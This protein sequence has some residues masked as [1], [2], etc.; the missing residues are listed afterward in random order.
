MLRFTSIPT[1]TATALLLMAIACGPVV[2]SSA[3]ESTPE[4][5]DPPV[6]ATYELDSSGSYFGFV[7]DQTLKAR[8]F[9]PELNQL[10]PAIDP[11]LAASIAAEFIE[12]TRIAIGRDVLIDFCGDGEGIT[13]AF[14][15]ATAFVDQPISW[16][17]SPNTSE[18]WNQP[19]VIIEF[20][21]P[22]LDIPGFHL[23]LVVQGPFDGVM[24][25][26][27][28]SGVGNNTVVFDNPTCGD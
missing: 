7:G 16:S 17:V 12:N 26:W 1:F 25:S 20:E 10:S 6:T 11:D 23:E 22:E 28:P 21:D 9:P 2:G 14:S 15:V 8:N 19:T 24:P 3:A 5:T 4:T 13:R 27:F 18:K